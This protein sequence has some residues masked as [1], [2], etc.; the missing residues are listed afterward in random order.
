ML[1]HSACARA[2]LLAL[3]I[4]F[5]AGCSDDDN[6]AGGGPADTTAPSVTSVT[7]IDANHIEVLFN[8]NVQRGSAETPANYVVVEAAP[9][10]ASGG[11]PSDTLLIAGAALQSDQRTVSLTTGPMLSVDYD[12]SVDGVKD[13][14][15]NTIDTPVERSFTGSSDPDATAPELVY[16][17][18]APNAT[19]VALG[20]Q[21]WLTFS[22]PVTFPSFIAGFTISDGGGSVPYV[23]DSDDNGIHIVVQPTSP[24]ELGTQYTIEL[25]GIQDETGNTMADATWTFTTTNTAD[26]TPPTVVSSSPAGGALNVDVNTSLSITFS[27]PINQ[28][29]LGISSYP[30]LGDG[31]VVWSNAGKTLTFTPLVPLEAD[32]QYTISAVP[33]GFKDLAGN[34]NTSYMQIRFSTGATLATGSF[35]GDVAGDPESD[36]AQN[37]A[38]ARV[39]AVVGSLEDFGNLE[40]AGSTTVT[41][42][43][44]YDLRN[45]ADGDFYALAIKNTNNDGLLDPIHGDAFGAFGVDFT[46]LD[47]EAD[48]VSIAGGNRVTGIDFPLYD[49]SAIGGTI[50]YDGAYAGG[51]HFVGV[52]LFIAETFDPMSPTPDFTTDV[53]WPDATE[54][55]FIDLEHGFPDDTYYVGAFL[56]ANDNFNYDPSDPIGIYG[57]LAAPTEINILDGS[58]RTGIVITLSD[59]LARSATASVRWQ[60]QP[61]RALPAWLRSVSSV[62]AKDQKEKQW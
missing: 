4:A 51:E 39:F 32:Q 60:T 14:S 59:P 1:R 61:K 34:G 5:L 27:E 46:G 57:G 62:I 42:Y 43:Y 52:G 55:V 45:L 3:S 21:I 48:T 2:T 50:S 13:V 24:L 15:G 29:E 8:E 56:D 54:W 37:S 11:V 17:S 41:A 36:F 28:V 19:N 33:G 18:P 25:T 49:P 47:T 20:T 30:D 44:D 10:A 38:G 9:L 31:D 16:R 7:S 23:G 53:S 6:P 35:A 12:M 58:D 26:T 22:E 40:V